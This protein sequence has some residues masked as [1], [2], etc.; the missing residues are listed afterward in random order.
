MG[1]KGFGFR[2]QRFRVRRING[3]RLEG[4]GFRMRGK[5]FALC[6][7]GDGLHAWRWTL[8]GPCSYTPHI[9]P[10]LKHVFGN[11]LGFFVYININKILRGQK[12]HPCSLGLLYIPG[13]RDVKNGPINPPINYIPKYPNPKPKPLK[14][15]KNGKRELSQGPTAVK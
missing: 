8:L 5:P 13:T 15:T 10:Y 3:L 14:P 11:S 9:E 7:L 2:V 12:T 6:L 4:L 1:L